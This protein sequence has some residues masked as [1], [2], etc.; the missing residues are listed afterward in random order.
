MD[1]DTHQILIIE[2]DPAHAEA[3]R[4]S[5]ESEGR[6]AC[7]RVA[8]SLAEARRCIV[9]SLP[10][11][12]IADLNLC[13]GKSYDLIKD[14]PKPDFPLL[15][16]TS[17][18]DEQM[19]VQALKA[20]ALDYAVKS[21]ETF[22]QM[23]RLVERMLREWRNIS[24]RAQAQRALQESER[25]LIDI[26]DFLP[27]ATL[28]VDREGHLIA[29]NHAMERMTGRNKARVLGQHIHTQY[30]AFY[31]TPHPVLLDAVLNPEVDFSADYAY[32]KRNGDQIVAEIYS[33]TLN[34]GKGAH[35][36][37]VAAP[38]FNTDRE[39][40]GAIESIRDISDTKQAQ[41][42]L[43]QAYGET[44]AITEAVHD[45]LYMVDRRGRLIWW[46][47]RV[48]EE[49]G[50]SAE[51]LRD[52]P[53]SD[54]FVEDDTQKMLDAFENA[55][56]TGYGEVECQ[57]LTVNGLRT[58]RYN[59][60]PVRN[61]ADT[62]IG[63]AGVGQDITASVR[64]HEEL[65]LAATVLKN[66]RE[67]LM[68]SDAQ[69]DKVIA[70]N[71]AFTEITGYTQTEALQGT[72]QL[73]RSGRHEPAFYQ[74]M[75]ASI[76]RSGHWQGEIW[77]RRKNGELFPAW[78]T[79]STVRDA[80][81]E[82][83]NYVAIFSDISTIKQSEAQ[84]E[85]LAHY[86]P[87]TNLPNRLLLNSRLEHAIQRARRKNTKV[88]VLF[89]DL[90]RFKHVNDSLG[91]PVGD[92]L[93]QAVARRLSGRIRSEDTLARLGGDEFVVLLESIAKPGECG[94]VAQMII[95]LMQPP[96]RLTG[97]REIYVGASIGISIYPDNGEH[98]T[99]LLRNADTAMSQ[100]K[101]Q[102]RNTYR[103]Y[104]ESLTRAANARLTLE[105]KLRHALD[106]EEFI[107]YFQPQ[108]SMSDERILGVEALVRWQDPQ[109]GLVQPGRFIPLAEETRLIVPLGAWVLRQSCRQM[110]IWRDAGLPPMTL[111]VNLSIQ[112]FAQRDLAVQVADILETFDLPSSCLELELT[113]S[114]LMQND[115]HGIDILNE[116]QELGVGLAIDDF[117]TGYSSLAYLKR[118]PIDKLKIDKSFVDG[119]PTDRNDAEIATTIIA[120][121]HNL[122]LSVLA[123]G[124]ETP[125][126]RAF[127]QDS[128]CDSYQGYLF[129]RP[130]PAESIEALFRRT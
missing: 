123:E 12:V 115:A 99:D 20:G 83:T 24:E 31:D 2:D 85:H 128:G 22:A 107:V 21:P 19:A 105:S 116:L 60:V 112:Q 39:L 40:A 51:S 71:P 35:L 26:I 18:G 72:T 34:D 3:V 86:D 121:A 10:D 68:I 8:A 100:A 15:V 37:I 84:L 118:L 56:N 66:I 81:G 16:M 120:M 1:P 33:P 87:L 94:L 122:K 109:E 59:G 27:D 110:R 104:M 125:E 91:H 82:I 130:V 48:E 113:E 64:S 61:A 44:R 111:A 38:L 76:K 4:R 58:Y 13:D 17:Q 106:N 30:S 73:L 50:C 25:R 45:I 65:R 6:F 46:N 14:Q 117:G 101:A 126:Q 49:T 42:E 95:S 80:S 96:F 114:M 119:I 98:A 89:M 103:Y 36:W 57:A 28:A 79:I 129:S 52:R 92:E 54:F 70:I 74:A 127:L 93:L 41:I 77:N 124:V 78:L 67:G 43:Q 7:I 5:L 29:W 32:I 69:G 97:A 108:V 62:I 90:D 11:A 55:W 75:W 63:V 47:K 88:A 9:E 23:P 53:F 102:G